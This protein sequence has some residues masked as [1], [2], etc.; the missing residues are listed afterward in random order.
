MA[1]NIIIRIIESK[2]ENFPVGRHVVGQ[3]GWRTLTISDGGKSVDVIQ[4]APYLVPDETVPLPL[5]LG[6]LGMPG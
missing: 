6:I 4:T 5:Y 1:N 3:F 2:N